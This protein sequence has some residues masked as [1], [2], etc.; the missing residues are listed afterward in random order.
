MTNCVEPGSVWTFFGYEECIPNTGYTTPI[1]ELKKVKFS[2]HNAF[3][4]NTAKIIQS[5]TNYF[6]LKNKSV[7]SF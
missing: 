5:R 1:T 4:T 3:I 7:I 6:L 2:E